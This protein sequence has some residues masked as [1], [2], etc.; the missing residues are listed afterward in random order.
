[1]RKANLRMNENYKYTVIQNLVEKDDN[2]LR[3]AK[4]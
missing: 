4:N 2:K 1:M 3:A